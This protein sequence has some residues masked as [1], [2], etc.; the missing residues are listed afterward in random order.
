MKTFIYLWPYIRAFLF[1][2][3]LT[4]SVLSYI[5]GVMSQRSIL[6]DQ[7]LQLVYSQERQLEETINANVEPIPITKRKH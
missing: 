6:L 5:L 3:L 1:G 7:K 2:V 4:F